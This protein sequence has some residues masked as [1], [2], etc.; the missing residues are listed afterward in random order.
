MHFIP[1]GR[2]GPDCL[3]PTSSHHP[4]RCSCS[5]PPRKPALGEGRCSGTAARTGGCLGSVPKG[6][7]CTVSGTGSTAQPRRCPVPCRPR[8]GLPWQHGS[9][10]RKLMTGEA[11]SQEGWSRR[12]PSGTREAEAAPGPGHQLHGCHRDRYHSPSSHVFGGVRML[13]VL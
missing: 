10:R 1:S 9:R 13:P 8:E 7:G 6:D 12:P 3:S 4:V 2:A 11:G 5:H